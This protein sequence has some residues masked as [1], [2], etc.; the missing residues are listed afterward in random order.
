MLRERYDPMNLFEHIAALGIETDAVLTQIH[1]LRDNDVLFQAVKV[2]E[3][4]MHYP[5]AST[6]LADG[7]RVLARPAPG[8]RL[9]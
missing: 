7:V 1:T 5:V 6:L 2:V 9:Q 8:H 4:N 3:T